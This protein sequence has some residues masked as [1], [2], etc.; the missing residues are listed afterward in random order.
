M[1]FFFLCQ[2]LSGTDIGEIGPRAPARSAGDVVSLWWRRM[3]LLYIFT[4]TGIC[5]TS[6]IFYLVYGFRGEGGFAGSGGGTGWA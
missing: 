3:Q 6:Y 2:S 5:V 1:C 4:Q